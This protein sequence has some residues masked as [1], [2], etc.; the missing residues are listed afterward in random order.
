MKKLYA[1]IERVTIEIK[2][3]KELINEQQELKYIE[4]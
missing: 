2:L 3:N 1:D 4:V